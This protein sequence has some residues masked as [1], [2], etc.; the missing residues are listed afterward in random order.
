MTD[1]Q[2]AEPHE[3]RDAIARA[4]KALL[5]KVPVITF[6]IDRDLCVREIAGGGLPRP[7]YDRSPL[8]G[9][10]ARELVGTDETAN[11]FEAMLVLALAGTPGRKTLRAARRSY[12][13]IVEPMRSEDGSVVGAVGLALNVSKQVDGR[14][15]LERIEANLTR[16]SRLAKLTWWHYEFGHRRLTMS[17][18]ML[19]LHGVESGEQPDRDA[20]IALVHPND[21]KRIR[22][23]I[24]A[25]LRNGESCRGLDYR[26]L[27]PD[28]SYYWFLLQIEVVA[29]AEG[30]P[31]EMHGT[32]IDITD[33][34][35]LEEHLRRLAHV[36]SLTGLANRTWLGE[37]LVESLRAGAATP[38]TALLFI[39][40]DGFK[41]VN[42]T[43]GH[44][45]GD[46]LL[47]EVANRIKGCLR[48]GD[49]VARSGGDEFVVLMTPADNADDVGSLAA[50]IVS[51]CAVP[52]AVEG[53]ELFTSI[54]IG[55]SIAPADATTPNALL[56]NADS[57]LYAAKLAGRNTFR[58]FTN[59]MHAAAARQLALE[60]DLRRAVERDEVFLE[61]QPIVSLDGSVRTIEALARWR[62]PELGLVEPSIFIP[63]AEQ[64]GTIRTIGSYLATEACRALRVWRMTD[65]HL[66]LALNISAFQL[67]HEGLAGMLDEA[68]ADAGL[69][70]NALELEVTETVVMRDVG[71]AAELLSEFKRRGARISIDDFGTG[72]SS[73]AWLKHLPIDTLKIDRSFIADI[74]TDA[75]DL[76]IVGSILSLARALRLEVVAEG[77]EDGG[78]VET[79]RR[80]GCSRFQG[81]VFSPPVPAEAI[82]EALLA[83]AAP[84]RESSLV[85]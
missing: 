41:A 74:E 31:L 3:D 13:T 65:P 71:R 80:L 45:T 18:E 14:R 9:R 77:V 54:S 49:F 23:A 79:L 2:R 19:R 37:R 55:I 69:G 68:L 82:P 47:K 15:H 5:V 84:K 30:T 43:Y 27:Q 34:K 26:L 52:Y 38:P 51:T 63:V 36:D 83:L 44:G 66:R 12:D 73:L 39:D 35:H 59:S 28:G 85:E 50:R 24:V 60:T 8:I 78:Q 29:S 21:R 16:A 53:R 57:A 10:P 6:V 72:Y 61:Y 81:F 40:V 4:F 64:T 32:L 75:E 46:E 70:L 25:A 20:F 76:A 11:E 1:G 67:E 7:R 62:H 58:F 56:R 48:A 17:D 22:A 42:D 33:R